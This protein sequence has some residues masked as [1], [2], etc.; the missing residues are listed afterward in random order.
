MLK[1]GKSITV[2]AELLFDKE[3]N[4]FGWKFKARN[5]KGRKIIDEIMDG[6]IKGLSYCKETSIT[7]FA[8]GNGEYWITICTPPK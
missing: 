8:G 3:G 5:T 7:P 2:E 4:F 1:K 6:K